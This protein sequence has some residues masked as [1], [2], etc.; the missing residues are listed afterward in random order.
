[1]FLLILLLVIVATK[2]SK[3]GILIMPNE[4]DLGLDN[5]QIKDV[6]IAKGLRTHG[7]SGGTSANPISE[8]TKDKPR[9][10]PPKNQAKVIK[11]TPLEIFNKILFVNT[12]CIRK[13]N[14]ASNAKPYTFDYQSLSKS[15]LHPELPSSPP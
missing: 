1:M 4:Y 13:S 9:Q 3:T 6:H 10:K 12:Y 11:N 5:W 8:K 7:R 14:Y 2:N 15:P